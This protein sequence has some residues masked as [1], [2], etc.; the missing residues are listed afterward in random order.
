MFVL[1]LTAV[2][3][4]NRNIRVAIAI[5]REIDAFMID[6]TLAR[7]NAVVP[8]RPKILRN[9]VSVIPP[10]LSDVINFE[11]CEIAEVL[12]VLNITKCIVHVVYI[13]KFD[14]ISPTFIDW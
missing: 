7:V 14:Y 13:L 10:R 8:S 1:L 9:T 12:I 3:K 11:R 2:I 6:A 5:V 4:R